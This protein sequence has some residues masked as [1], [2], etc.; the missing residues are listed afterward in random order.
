M[1]QFDGPGRDGAAGARPVRAA[2]RVAALRKAA[3]RMGALQAAQLR[4]VAELAEECTASARAELAGRPPSWGCPSETELVVSLVKHELMVVLG[5]P[6]GEAERLE[7]LATRLVR[8]LPDTLVAVEAGRLDLSRARVLAEA[9]AVLA[10]AAARAV[11]AL[12]LPAAGAGPWE[13]PSPRAWRALVHKTVV[14]VDADAARRRRDVAV[15]ARAVRAWLWGDG[16]GVLQITA[17]DYD[18]VRADRILTDLAN[19]WPAADPADPAGA[20]L[21][22]DQ[23]RVDALMDLLRRLDL[24]AGSPGGPDLPRVTVRREREVGIVLHADTLFGDGPAAADPGEL[25]GMGAPAPLDPTTARDAARTEIAAGAGTRVLLVDG[26]GVMQRTIRL[27]QA[28]PEGWTRP[29]LNTA[30][31]AGLAEGLPALET[32]GYVPTVAIT[33]HVRAVHPRCTAYDCARAARRSDLDHDQ[34][35]PRGPTSVTNLCPRCRR[36]HIHKTLGLLRTRL[37]RDGS[38]TTTTLLG[39]RVTTRPDP[40]PGHGLGEAYHQ[41]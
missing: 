27:P 34:P 24:G 20:P 29:T 31:R 19:T 15:K 21:S 38:V 26:D 2:R 9:T 35:W 4:L 14:R 32:D 12:V 41:G 28:P 18:I 13:G 22:M 17:A 23:R 37:H 36:H 39:V 6:A 25:R 7:T 3:R 16:T 11:E 8:V 33:E 5:I 1:D 10:D 30:V 40:L